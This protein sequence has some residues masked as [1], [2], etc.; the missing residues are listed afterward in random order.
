VSA[1][2]NAGG[3]AVV[4]TGASAGVGRSTACSAR[5]ALPARGQTGLEQA[6]H[7]VRT[8]GGRALPLVV[9]VADPEAV[10]AA[11][12]PVEDQLGPIDVR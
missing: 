6:A 3:Q 12:Q 5:A 4:I 8:S 11:A 9:D 1:G 7:D 2:E 10:E